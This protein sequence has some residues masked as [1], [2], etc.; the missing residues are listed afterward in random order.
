MYTPDNAMFITRPNVYFIAFVIA[1][2]IS[3]GKIVNS[4][5]IGKKKESKIQIYSKIIMIILEFAKKY[6]LFTF[7]S[8][9]LIISKLVIWYL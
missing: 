4:L 9:T 7:H 8:F 6:I 1:R 3:N 2:G 5:L